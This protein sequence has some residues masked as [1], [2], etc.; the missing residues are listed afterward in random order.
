MIDSCDPR[1]NDAR[2]RD[3]NDGFDRE[4]YRDSRER[5]DDPRDAMLSNLDLPRGLERELVLDR[6]RV[7]ELTAKTAGRSRRLARSASS[8]SVISIHRTG[9]S[10]AATIALSTSLTRA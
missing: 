5:G 9:V 8:Q 2:D 3:A 7:Y 6:D 10:I 4:I 1:W